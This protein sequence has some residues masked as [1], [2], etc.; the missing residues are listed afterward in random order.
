MLA[1]TE[2]L[3]D[4]TMG[5]GRPESIPLCDEPMTKFYIPGQHQA[6]LDLYRKP[7][8]EGDPVWRKN[9]EIVASYNSREW[10][11]QCEFLTLVLSRATTSNR[12]RRIPSSCK[13]ANTRSSTPLLD[14]RFIRV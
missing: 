2:D 5:A 1:H 10:M 14:Q 12:T 8:A 3:T 9:L 13:A 7:Q 4:Y 6:V 11:V